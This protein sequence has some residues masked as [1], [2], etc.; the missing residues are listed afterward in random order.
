MSEVNVNFQE[1]KFKPGTIGEEIQRM[2]LSRAVIN[3]EP[4]RES[5]IAPM[6]SS[7]VISFV[8]FVLMM[9]VFGPGWEEMPNVEDVWQVLNG[10]D[11]FRHIG[12]SIALSRFLPVLFDTEIGDSFEWI[13]A[14]KITDV[15]NRWVKKETVQS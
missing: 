5:P 7:F 2:M 1:I 14:E 11:L 13:E 9:V 6:L 4:D 10:N 12:L 15:Y 8:H 3:G